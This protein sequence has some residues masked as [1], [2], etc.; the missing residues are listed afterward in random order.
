MPISFDTGG[1]QQADATR[2]VDPGTGDMAG[3][4]YFDL[5]PDLP[6][7]LEDVAT[8]RAR[9]TAIHASTGG[10]IEAWVIGVDG[11]PALLR[12]EKMRHRDQPTGLVFAASI[13][14]PKDRCSAVLMLFCE[15]TGITGMREAMTMAR[16]GFESMYPPHPYAPEV[17]GDL[18]YNRADAAEFDADFPDHPLSRVRAWLTRT[19]PTIRLDP[20]FAALPPFRG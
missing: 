2:W 1:F 3:V 10:L 14:V 5:P 16:L 8:L 19:V 17:R 12:I 6:A 18:P 4:Q 7:S 13:V 20:A 11:Q 9:L 15:E